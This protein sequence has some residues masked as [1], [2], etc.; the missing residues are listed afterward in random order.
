MDVLSF[1]FGKREN[2]ELGIKEG[3]KLLS[4]ELFIYLCCSSQFV[5]VMHVSKLLAGLDVVS[6]GVP[7]TLHYIYV[8]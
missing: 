5:Y 8:P 4:T 2:L 7:I 1:T 3:R 6:M